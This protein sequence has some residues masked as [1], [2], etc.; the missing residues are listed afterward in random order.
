MHRHYFSLFPTCRS[1]ERPRGE[2]RGGVFSDGIS[3]ALGRLAAQSSESEK[4]RIDDIFHSSETCRSTSVRR[5]RH[6]EIREDD[7]SLTSGDVCAPA[8][9][10]GVKN[11]ASAI[12]FTL[13]TRISHTGSLY[14]SLFRPALSPA[15]TLPAGAALCAALGAADGVVH[16]GG[17]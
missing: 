17:R 5:H 8:Q 15:G 12:F 16:A 13:S 11:I 1:P 6:R 7:F 4:Y 10:S 14:I 9:T 2:I 3:G